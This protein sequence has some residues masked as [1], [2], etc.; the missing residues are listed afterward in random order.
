MV[1]EMKILFDVAIPLI[2]LL[3]VL[4]GVAWAIYRFRAEAPHNPRIEFD[5]QASFLGPQLNYFPTEIIVVAHNK[6]LRLRKFESIELRVRGIP[7]NHPIEEWRGNEP[8][9]YLPDKVFSKAEM[10][11]RKFGHLFVEPGVS[12]QITFFARVPTRYRFVSIRAEFR[13][14]H[15]R[16]HSAER[17]FKTS[18]QRQAH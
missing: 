10:V 14:D 4:G 16:T 17:L 7:D 9:L 15:T 5:I 11:F 6:G 18:I 2:Q 3:V 12:Q 1:D 13:Y 8:R